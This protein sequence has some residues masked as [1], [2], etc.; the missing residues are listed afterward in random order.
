ML[1]KLEIF[2]GLSD[3]DI[4]PIVEAGRQRVFEDKEILF[5]EGEE[6]TH[7]FVLGRGTVLVS[8]LTESGEESLINVLS[9]G[10]IFPH[11]GF[12]DNRPYPGTAQAKK[13][14]HV[15]MIPISAFELFLKSHP[16]L[17]FQIIKV[18]NEKI[19]YLQQKL[20]EVLSLNVEQRLV[21]A[22][23]HL[24]NVQ[25]K[26]IVLTHQEIGNIIG[27]TRET[28]SRQLKKMEQ[29]GEVEVKKDRIIIND[30]FNKMTA[31]K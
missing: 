18:M 24:K 16:E 1:R 23:D 29:R 12:F 5:H 15:L 31:P 17:A 11:T 8:K 25:G 7:L 21:A 10:E 22:L 26:S 9:E 28:V 4:K 30:T 3:Q 6:R 2:S 27:T 20:N 14:V 19:F 13:N